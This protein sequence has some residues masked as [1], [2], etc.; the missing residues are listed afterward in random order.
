MIGIRGFLLGSAAIGALIAGAASAM[1]GGLAVREQS[2][3]SQGASF[4]GASAGGD[5]SSTF[6]NPA[7]AGLAGQGLTSE[8]HGSLIIPNVDVRSNSITTLPG[9]AA[10]AGT[11]VTGDH[12]HMDR[13]ALVGSSY[14]AYRWNNDLVLGLAINAPFGLANETSNDTWSGARHFRSAKLFTMTA[15]PMASYKLAPGLF[16]GAG[17]QVQYASLVFKANPSSGLA[18]SQGNQVL[19]GDDIGFG[20]TGGLLW[21]PARGTNI[22]LGYRSRVDHTIEG[23]ASMAN[24]LLTTGVGLGTVPF[25]PIGFNAALT[26]PDIANLSIRQDISPNMRLLGSVEWTNWSLVN[27]VNFISTSTGGISAAPTGPNTLLTQFDF[28]WKDGWMFSV[29]GE[30]DWSKQLTLRSGVAYEISPIQSATSR[31][32]NITDADRIWLSVG[33]NYKWSQSMTFDF[34][35]SHVFIDDAA[36]DALTTSPGTATTPVRR[37]LGNVSQGADI[38]SFAVKTKW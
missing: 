36:I 3:S 35:Y 11:V 6:W 17:V 28:H 12:M 33:G 10:P 19:D 31:K 23:S 18:P 30:Y 8:N 27:K 26:T 4:A 5:L 15:N 7:A 22:G 25:R 29:G 37:L 24:G 16:L 32:A 13:V 14:Y 1:A 38:V 34:A 20:Y 21:Q 2:T 9:S